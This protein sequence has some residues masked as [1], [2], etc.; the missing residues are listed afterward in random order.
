M[1]LC[2][3]I[4][5]KLHYILCL[6]HGKIENILFLHLFLPRNHIPVKCVNVNAIPTRV[7]ENYP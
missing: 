4:K 6:V 2:N 3:F 1:K 5:L 7:K